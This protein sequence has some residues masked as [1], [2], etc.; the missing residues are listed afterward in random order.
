M[1]GGSLEC[2]GISKRF[3]RVQALV[4]LDLTIAAGSIHAVVGHNGAGKSTLAQII[5]GQMPADSGEV[6]YSGAVLDQGS[7]LA[8]RSAGIALVHQH[9]MLVPAFTAGENLALA[10]TEST[11]GFLD[12]GGV[13]AEGQRIAESLGWSIP[14]TRKTS[15][16]DVGVRQRLE[17][18]KALAQGAELLILDE[19]TATLSNQETADLLEAVK[20]LAVQ[21]MTVLLIAHKLQEVFSVADE[22]TVLRGGR[23]VLSGAAGDLN[24]EQVA[25]AMLGGQMEPR[26]Q[27]ADWTPGEPVLKLETVSTSSGGE[28]ADLRGV[29]LVVRSGEI[30]GIGGVDGNG[31]RALAETAVELRAASSGRVSRP[32]KFAYVPGDR[33]KEGL[34]LGMTLG[35]NVLAGHESNPEFNRWGLLRGSVIREWAQTLLDRFGL[36]YRDVGQSARE[37][38]GGNQQKLI[39]ARSLEGDPELLV[40]VNPSRGLDIGAVAE[41]EQALVDAARAGCGVLLITTDNEELE[42][43]CSRVQY[44]G[45]GRVFETAQEALAAG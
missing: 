43:I 42:R 19:P 26:D 14:W 44:L 35:E 10:M 38:S 9:F 1:G 16:L 17:V 4:D 6:L 45:S 5:A 36:V 7:P 20:N 33:H 3:G 11:K 28:V 15:E 39:L 31:Q 29:D 13:I 23:K 18:V 27:F 41:I 8:A 34:A 40:C 25:D 30:L 32:E 2:R 21:G 37:L 12:L 24:P 22:I